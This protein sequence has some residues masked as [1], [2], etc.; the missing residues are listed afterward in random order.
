ME[1][2]REWAELYDEKKMRQIYGL[3]TEIID[4]DLKLDSARPLNHIASIMED[5]ESF[6]RTLLKFRRPNYKLKL[7]RANLA[8]DRLYRVMNDL[9]DG[10]ARLL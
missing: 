8:D 2:N 3:I 7:E 1:Y 9:I 10:G 5:V 4:G 6:K